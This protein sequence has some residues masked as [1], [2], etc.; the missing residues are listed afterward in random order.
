MTLKIWN[1]TKAMQEACVWTI[2]TL[3]HALML[4]S[5]G[6]DSMIRH[7][8]VSQLLNML[9]D[10]QWNIDRTN[11]CLG[12]WYQIQLWSL[13]PA[14]T[15]MI[16][17]LCSNVFA[18]SQSYSILPELHHYGDWAP[19]PTHI[20]FQSS[21]SLDLASCDCGVAVIVLAIVVVISWGQQWRHQ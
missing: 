15:P 2:G 21:S 4:W 18:Y 8:L 14:T 9:H 12:L 3:K 1:K 5:K 17:V 7:V 19:I 11:V 16:W 6:M 13:S 10:I 20:F